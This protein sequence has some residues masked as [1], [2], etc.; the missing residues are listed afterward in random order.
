MPF[1]PTCGSISSGRSGWPFEDYPAEWY[2]YRQAPCWSSD[3]LSDRT[4]EGR[5]LKILPGVDD[6]ARDCLTILVERQRQSI[7]VLER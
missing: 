2:P 3:F 1:L 6:G 4:H 5:P 7:D